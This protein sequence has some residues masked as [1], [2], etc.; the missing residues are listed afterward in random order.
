[1]GRGAVVIHDWNWAAAS[2]RG[3]SHER[4]G[5]RIQDAFASFVTGEGSR[6]HFVGVVCDGA[7][8]AERGGEGA[9]LVCRTISVATRNHFRTSDTVPSQEKVQEWLDSARDLISAVASRR[10]LIPRDF[11]AT[12]VLAIS[13][14]TNSLVAHVGDGCAVFKD[15]SLGAWIAPSWPY[16]GEYASTT[17]FVTDEDGPRLQYVIH[18]QPIVAMAVFSDGIERLVLDLIAKQPHQPFFENMFRSLFGKATLG[19]DRALSVQLKAYLNGSSIN[20]R[21]DDDK[22]LVLSVRR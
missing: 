16:H 22:S 13:N 4:A 1:M 19:R 17:A 5:T 9:S 6:R 7:G 20:S 14:G 18:D 8:S 12:L 10:N 21:T 15:E 11:A 2:C 3:V